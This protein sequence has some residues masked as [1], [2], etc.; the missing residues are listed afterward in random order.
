MASREGS[1]SL[2]SELSITS[3]ED[4]ERVL[5]ENNIIQQYREHLKQV[6]D[7]ILT[8][9]ELETNRSY[10]EMLSDWANEER[11]KIIRGNL[12]KNLKELKEELLAGITMYTK[13]LA[14]KEKY[15]KC[16]QNTK[17]MNFENIVV[18]KGMSNN[19][20]IN[21]ATNQIPLGN[22]FE[23]SRTKINVIVGGVITTAVGLLLFQTTNN[24]GIAGVG[25]LCMI[26]LVLIYKFAKYK[27]KERSLKYQD[28]EKSQDNLNGRLLDEIRVKND[29]LK[30]MYQAIDKAL[31]KRDVIVYLANSCYSESK[32][33][34]LK[35][36]T[37]DEPD[38]T[39]ELCE[40]LS[41]REAKIACKSYLK[42]EFNCSN[43]EAEEI[44]SEIQSS[45][46]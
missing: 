1:A 32:E 42:R 27:G 16:F 36:I 34:A 7:C 19:I 10:W 24:W 13:L 29:Q 31:H 38:I 35:E 45:K 33:K 28:V 44:L 40:T 2:Q 41:K 20:V 6:N 26:G 30:K 8:F 9:E 4:I 15:K 25:I 11:H 39:A 18:E 21:D 14:Q 12:M 37:D 5:S 3:F 17:M 46:E 23:V 43:E 22:G